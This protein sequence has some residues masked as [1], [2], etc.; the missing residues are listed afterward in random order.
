MEALGSRLRGND[1]YSFRPF[2]KGNFTVSWM[3]SILR[4]E[5]APSALIRS[6]T[7]C[8]T[9]SGAE[10]PAVKPTRVCES[11]AV[12]AGGAAHHDHHVDVARH[13]LHGV[14][15]V[16]RR[17]ADVLLLRLADAGKALLDRLADLRR[18]VHRQR[19]LGHHRQPLGLR[20]LHPGH[21]RH[22]LHQV[23]AV[24]QLAHGAFDFR[25]ALVADHDEL[26]AFLGQLGHLDV[27]LRHQR[28]GGVEH[29]EA[30]L[31]RLCLHRLADAVRG[32]H[33]RGPGRH[34]RQVLDEDGALGLEVVDDEGVV[35]DLVAHV[36]RAAEL[37]EG[38][39]H[40]VDGAVHAGAEA[41]RFGQQD[42]LGG[43]QSTPI[44]CTSKVT[45]WPASGWLKSNSTASGLPSPSRSSPTCRTEPAYWPRPSGV[46][47]LTTSPTL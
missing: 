30:A 32:E 46:G 39:L 14:L 40:D 15:P 31:P 26:V 27:H 25:M 44:T 1:I 19:G 16:L 2:G 23:D 12:G 20:G 34:L 22:V 43:H 36:D 45:G 33:Q 38:A 10:A 3:P 8:T 28:A 18:V 13:H 42:L 7:S 29:V 4:T 5:T 17:V 6:I 21:V 9:T 24:V 11:I 37:L 35:H 47:K 41:A